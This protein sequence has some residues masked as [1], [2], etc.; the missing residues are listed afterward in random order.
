MPIITTTGITRDGFVLPPNHSWDAQL[1]NGKKKGIVTVKDEYGRISHK[2]EYVNDQLNGIAEFYNHG[3]L[4]EKRTFVNNIEEGWSCEYKRGRE[5]RWFMYSNGRKTGEL[6]QYSSFMGLCISMKLGNYW[7]NYSTGKL[8][9]SGCDVNSYNKQGPGRTLS[10]F[11]LICKILRYLICISLL[12]RRFLVHR[13]Y[14]VWLL[15]FVFLFWHMVPKRIL[16]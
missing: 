8:E 13:V 2:L 7:Y 16:L 12:S 14:W 5:V 3:E 10:S 4:V 9:E 11:L 15:V 6:K 1:I